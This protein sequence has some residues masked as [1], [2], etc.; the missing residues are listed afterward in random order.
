M[1]Q[2]PVC[3]GCGLSPDAG[4]QLQWDLADPATCEPGQIVCDDLAGGLLYEHRVPTLQMRLQV[5]L[6]ISGASATYNG[7]T[8]TWTILTDTGSADGVWSLD[9]GDITVLCTDGVYGWSHHMAATVNFAD[10]TRYFINGPI[11]SW[12]VGPS[13]GVTFLTEN[14]NLNQ[15]ASGEWDPVVVFGALADTWSPSGTVNATVTGQP[16]VDFDV[17]VNLFYLGHLPGGPRELR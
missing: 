11:V 3:V 5:N 15:T 6:P 8:P 13:L 14:G 7:Q 10:F 16:S 4:G 17:R 9:N 1:P 12:V 2:V